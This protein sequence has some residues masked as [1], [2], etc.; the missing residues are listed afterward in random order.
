MTYLFRLVPRKK[1]FFSIS[2]LAYTA[3]YQIIWPTLYEFAPNKNQE[4]LQ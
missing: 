1:V 2:N 4:K 3:L